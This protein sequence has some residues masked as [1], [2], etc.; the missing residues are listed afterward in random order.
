VPRDSDETAPALGRYASW[1]ALLACLAWATLVACEEVAP[2]QNTDPPFLPTITNEWAN[3]ADTANHKFNL[4]SDDDGEEKGTFTGDEQHPVQG[5]GNLAGAFVNEQIEFVVD[6]SQ[7][8]P[9]VF[10]G[11]FI[12]SSTIQLTS[13]LGE[14]LTIIR[15]LQ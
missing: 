7:D 14:A 2:T 3:V 9:T 15:V 4:N 13:D 8:G 6:R 1:T 11:M 12:D 10:R 5:P